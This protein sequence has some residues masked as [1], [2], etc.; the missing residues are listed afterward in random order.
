MIKIGIVIFS[1]E[2]TRIFDDLSSDDSIDFKPIQLLLTHPLDF[3]KSTI[4][5]ENKIN[6]R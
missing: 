6:G 5:E 1:F 3:Q 4:A 2:S